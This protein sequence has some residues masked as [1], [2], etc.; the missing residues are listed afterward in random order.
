MTVLIRSLFLI[1][2][3]VPTEITH[4]VGRDRGL[5]SKKTNFPGNFA[6]GGS[7][8]STVARQQEGPEFE[9][10]PW[11]LSA[12]SLHVLPTSV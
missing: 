9:S 4:Q 11:G 7:V 10:R 5:H 8:V 12:R 1:A 6:F 2:R 3:F